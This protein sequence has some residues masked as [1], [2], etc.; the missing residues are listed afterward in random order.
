LNVSPIVWL[1]LHSPLPTTDN[2]IRRHVL[3]P[4][5]LLCTDGCG[6]IEDIDH[7]FLSCG[8]FG[9]VCPKYL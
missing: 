8:F 6:T 7:L 5:A 1:L 9:K 3:D 2:L 4:N